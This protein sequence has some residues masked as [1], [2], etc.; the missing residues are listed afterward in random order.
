M[1]VRHKTFY[2]DSKFKGE[3][4]FTV[5]GIGISD[6]LVDVVSYTYFH[7]C[8]EWLILFYLKNVNVYH[9]WAIKWLAYNNKYFLINENMHM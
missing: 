2:H 9:C 8:Y 7:V 3:N 6:L 1:C 4:V 5:E